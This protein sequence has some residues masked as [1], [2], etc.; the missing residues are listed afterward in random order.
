MR[1]SFIDTIK[2]GM[3]LVYPNLVEDEIHVAEWECGGNFKASIYTLHGRKRINFNTFCSE[4]K[5]ML[6]GEIDNWI[7]KEMYTAHNLF[8]KEFNA[9]I[10]KMVLIERFVEGTYD[11]TLSPQ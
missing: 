4:Y 8:K 9:A 5:F 7:K 2:K 3:V 11:I 6:E 1:Q 10:R